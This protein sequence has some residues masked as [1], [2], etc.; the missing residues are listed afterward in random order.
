[1][2][3]KFVIVCF[4]GNNESKGYMMKKRELLA[5]AAFLFLV[6]VLSF[7]ADNNGLSINSSG[8]PGGSSLVGIP[9]A[10]LN[11]TVVYPGAGNP[12]QGVVTTPISP[13]GNLGVDGQG[14]LSTPA[15]GPSGAPVGID[16]EGHASVLT[17]GQSGGYVGFDRQGKGVLITPLA[18]GS[19]VGIDTQG[20]TWTL[21]PRQ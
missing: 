8:A 19:Q 5:L 13:G 14:S 21:P 7:A 6:P 11:P 20:N 10:P 3:R 1:M 15:P 17:P 2:V 12:Q 4:S 9:V 16:S 18:P